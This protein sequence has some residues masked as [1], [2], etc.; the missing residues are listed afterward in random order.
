M[1]VLIERKKNEVRILRDRL[2]YLSGIRNTLQ[3]EKL[4][5]EKQKEKAAHMIDIYLKVTSLLQNASEKARNSIVS[6]IEKIVSEALREIIPEEK[7]SFK[8]VFENKRGTSEVKF[9]I[10]DENIKQELNVMHAFGGGIKDIIST[11]L[12]IV[13]LE[14]DRT[15]N[16]GPI[17]LD[18]TCSQISVEYQENFG[19]FLRILS[20]KLGRQIIL[21]TH[22]ENIVSQ[23][24]KIF[25]IEKID[26]KSRI[27]NA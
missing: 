10:F 2:S 3:E 22:E 7:L 1:L 23:A 18:E 27:C 17:I 13:V 6:R 5:K 4:Q 12:R 9:K 19:K 20:E 14:L 24:N 8:V 16:F 15:G 11:V 21:V 26:G 25:Q